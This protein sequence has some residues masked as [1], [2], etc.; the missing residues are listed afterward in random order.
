MEE[1]HVEG[2][3][4]GGG[5]EGRSRA[6]GGG[7]WERFRGENGTRESSGAGGQSGGRWWPEVGGD[8]GKGAGGDGGGSIGSKWSGGVGEGL[9]ESHEGEWLRVVGLTL[10]NPK[11]V[12]G[13][14]GLDREAE[15]L[16]LL[17][18]LTHLNIPSTSPILSKNR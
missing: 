2:G 5:E 17:H 15:K 12:A 7:D 18:Y 13:P 8:G 14:G 1:S 9:R 6:A 11:P 3:G 4:V 10:P 16:P